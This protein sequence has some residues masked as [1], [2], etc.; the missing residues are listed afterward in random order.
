MI[1]FWLLTRGCAHFSASAG[2]PGHEEAAGVG[3]ER[4]SSGAT[5]AAA[6]E[7][8]REGAG[9]ASARAARL[10]PHPQGQG[11]LSRE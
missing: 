8:A 2:A 7:S 5:A 11:A 3:R 10:Q 9:E 4:A 6:A 1:L